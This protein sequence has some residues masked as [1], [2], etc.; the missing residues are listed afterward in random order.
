MFVETTG[1]VINL[2]R[3]GDGPRLLLLH[4][5]PQTLATWHRIAPRLAWHF[6]VIAS[7]LRTTVGQVVPSHTL[8]LDLEPAGRRREELSLGGRQILVLDRPV[9]EDRTQLA[10]ALLQGA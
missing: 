10:G 4:G 7:H 1:A 3:A 8:Q 6:T 9:A 5:Y 2:V